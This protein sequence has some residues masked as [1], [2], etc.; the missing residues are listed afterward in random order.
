MK[1]STVRKMV[2]AFGLAFAVTAPTIGTALAQDYGHDRRDYDRHEH[3][4]MQ[5]ERWEREHHRQAVYEAPPVVYAP[6]RVYVAPPVVQEP[7]PGFSGNL[8]INL[9]LN[10]N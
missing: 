1:A 5:R 7:S 10:F 2:L 4:R 6:Q 3:E 8:N 9:P